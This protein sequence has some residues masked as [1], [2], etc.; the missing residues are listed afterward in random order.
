[1]PLDSGR[2]DSFMPR[3]RFRRGD[4]RASSRSDANRAGWKHHPPR[5]L[6]LEPLE[7]RLLLAS[8][9]IISEFLASNKNGLEDSFGVASDWIEIYNPDSTDAVDLTGWKLRY[10]S[11]SNAVDWYFPTMALG[12]GEY[13]ILFA[14]GRNITDPNGELH[15]NFSL[16]KDGE[17]LRLINGTTVVQDFDDYPAQEQD[18]SYGVGQAVTETTLLAAGATT[19]YYAPSDDSLGAAW[20]DP[21]FVDTSWSQGTTGLG[22]PNVTAG[23]AVWGYKANTTGTLANLAAA[24]AVIDVPAN[25]SWSL[26]ETSPTLNYWNTGGRGH[27]IY[28]TTYPGW[29]LNVLQT[30]YVV[31]ATGTIHIDT[32]GAT[33]TLGVNSDDGFRLAVSNASTGAAV[34]FSGAY[35]TGTVTNGALQYDA[36]RTSNDSLGVITFPAAGDYNLD[37]LYYQGSGTAEVELYA[38]Q[39]AF[40]AWNSTATWRLVGDTANGGLAVTSAPFT[41]VGNSVASATSTNVHAAMQAAAQHTSLYT[42]TTFDAAQWA[43]LTSLTLKM[44]YDDGYVAYV[45]GVE[46][47]RRNVPGSVTWDSQALAERTSEVQSSTFETIDISALLDPDN[48]YHLKASGNVLAVQVLSAS[49]GD[50]DLLML[51]EIAQIQSTQLGDHYFS[52]PTPAGANS[53][54]YWRKAEDPKF[55]VEHGFYDETF[56]LTLSTDTAGSRIYYTLDSSSPWYS[57]IYTTLSSGITRSGSTATVTLVT[58][59]YST[60][61]L[62]QVTGATQPEYNGVFRIFNAVQNTFSYTVSGTPASPS[63]GTISVLKVDSLVTSITRSGSTATATIADHGFGEG[64]LVRIVGASQ[65]AYNGDFAIFNVTQNTFD[66]TVVGE[67]ASPASGGAG[68]LKLGQLYTGPIAV[69]TTT[70]VR[71]RVYNSEFEPSDVV[72]QTY[73]FL[74]D[75]ITQPA[76][77]EGYP[78]S[79]ATVPSDYE[80][81]PDITQNAAYA[82][83][84][85]AALESLPTMSLVS[86]RTNWFDANTG[87]LANPTVSLNSGYNGDPMAVPVSLE[88]FESDGDDG[89]QIN[90]GAQV[91]GG[92]GRQPTYKKHSMRIV[93]SSTYGPTKLNYA[94]FGDEGTDEFDS[95]VLKSGFNDCWTTNG[96]VVQYIRDAFAS[97]M[98]LAMGDPDHHTQFVHLY[99]DGLYWGIYAATERPDEAFSS[100]YMGG[101]KEDWEANNSGYDSGV[102][103]NIPAWNDLMAKTKVGLTAAAYQAGTAGFTATTYQAGTAGFNTTLYAAGASTTSGF[104]STYYKSN[105]TVT[106]LADAESVIGTSSK[107]SSTTTQTASLINYLNTGVEGHFAGSGNFPGISTTQV[108]NFVVETT[109]SITI[110]TVGAWTFGV[111]SNDGFLLTLSNGTD[112]FTASS[113]GTRTNPGDTLQ[114]FTVTTAGSYR[115]RLV[116]FQNTGGAEVELYAAAGTYA[117]YGDTTGWRLVGD[118]ANG[119]LSSYLVQSVAS[120]ANADSIVGNPANQAW[121]ETVTAS[122]INYTNLG[123]DLRFTTGNS[124][125]PIDV[126]SLFVVDVTTTIT[127]PSAGQWTF[128]VSSDDGFRLSIGGVSFSSVSGSGTTILGGAMQFDGTRNPNDS[129][130]RVTFA[131]AGSYTLHLLYYQS[132]AGAEVELYAGSG[133]YTS[134]N[135]AMRLVGDTGNAGLLALATPYA[136][137]SLSAADTVLGTPSLQAWTNTQR[138]ATINYVNS[139]SDGRYSNGVA[140][141]GLT[142]T[143]YLVQNCVVKATSTISIPT[144][145]NWTFGVTSD[146]GFRLVLSN[147]MSTY[148][149]SYDGLRTSGDTLKTFAITTAGSY[150]LT[151]VYYQNTSAASLE[152]YATKGVYA[153]YADASSWQLVG[154]NVT[155][156][157]NTG[158]LSLASVKS[159]GSV[160]DAE[161]V[162]SQPTVA[163]GGVQA[164]STLASITRNGTVAT[165]TLVDHGLVNGQT[166]IIRGASQASYNGTFVISNV[167][168]DTFD[169]TVAGAP[170]TPA[171]GTLFVQPASLLLAGITRSGTTATATVAKHGLVNGQ[172][173]VVAGASPSDYNGTFVVSNVTQ[174][175]F[176]YTVLSTIAGSA[177]G[178][179]FATPAAISRS[180]M[181]AIVQAPNHGYAVGDCVTIS[182]AGQGEYNGTFPLTSVTANTFTYS[183]VGTPV[184]P[185]TGTIVAR[186]VLQAWSSTATINTI[187]YYATGADGHFGGSSVFPGM[188]GGNLM[189]NFVVEVK[190]TVSISSPG[191]WTFGVNSDEGFSLQVVDASFSSVSGAGTVSADVMSYDG[192]RTAGDSLGVI[193]FANAG[194]YTVRLVYFQKTA[195]AELELYA[196]AG[197]WTAWSDTT[198]WRLV[199]DSV[200]GGLGTTLSS[201]AAVTTYRANTSVTSLDEARAVAGDTAQQLSSTT[202]YRYLL[203]FLNTGSEGQFSGSTTFPGISATDSATEVDDFVVEVEATVTIP[204]AGAWTFNVNCD[205]GFSL[206]FFDG[207]TELSPAFERS[208]TGELAHGRATTPSNCS[209]TSTPAARGWNSRPHSR[210][211]PRGSPPA[212]LPWPPTSRA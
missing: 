13:R 164:K 56:G 94:L 170:P 144:T 41:G 20:T 48:P 176:D 95:I 21:D 105:T 59:G 197:A 162:I 68:A 181:T 51:P 210:R 177:T 76:D 108:D 212:A 155:A 179:I 50:T 66:Y 90:A 137:T 120:L 96:T 191:A 113:D 75:V 127:I 123:T 8:N 36:A 43:S 80:M 27:F 128:G 112:V 157:T 69:S 12:P 28:D 54:A 175:T 110:P 199:G 190:T 145:G 85:V 7:A 135:T 30:N 211:R 156:T 40:T 11:G 165:A 129:Y 57:D 159:V 23:F 111:S 46:V 63:T 14:T 87:I 97:D 124:V 139:G 88:Y 99:I 91:Y 154:S 74:A 92:V 153:N 126:R 138:P 29:K 192:L 186:N 18:I 44:A 133:N 195:G 185:G 168:E 65:S 114:T 45:N 15:T 58:H 37:L 147:G 19:R 163:T 55:S 202:E 205:D 142:S 78:G 161:Q 158:L 116:F 134:W 39:G 6:S 146:E 194:A 207:L 98:H 82:N 62:I 180:G 187:N 25:Q 184:S 60:G 204:S 32:A 9:P 171:T 70:T 83:Q 49:A 35:V 102:T 117:S 118:T 34:A 115:L 188:V 169:F 149:M 130:G 193:N 31:Q 77:P 148:S 196:A 209:T 203:D 166:V 107:Q 167:T 183:V 173:V 151:L 109:S 206:A 16:S 201:L 73:I 52:T 26:N 22:V 104:T 140:F 150:S 10:K 121:T 1:M 5:R 141:P 61:D 38:A 79:W 71:A 189:E 81:D 208:G 100:S 24:Q 33:W 119:G 125:F 2:E 53:Q 3:W 172:V 86:D 72:T 122:T 143:S 178:T 64:D 174:N 93:F 89:F 42:R 103:N 47:A 182:G 17:R 160:A 106:T 67:P 101:D 131:S 84:M 152:L 132:V 198:S 136:V 200:S 4:T